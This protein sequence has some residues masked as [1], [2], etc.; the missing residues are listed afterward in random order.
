MQQPRTK[1]FATQFTVNFYQNMKNFKR[2]KLCLIT[3]TFATRPGIFTDIKFGIRRSKISHTATEGRK[4]IP[5]FQCLLWSVE[6]I[7]FGKFFINGN[8][9]G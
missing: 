7:V 5:N 9:C 2:Q 1:I 6:Q 3:M 4:V 8:H